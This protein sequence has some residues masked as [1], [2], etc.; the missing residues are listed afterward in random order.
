IISEIPYQV[1]KSSM[2]ER[3]AELVREKRVEGISGLRDESDR[4]GM[5]VVI[6]L[7]R[8]ASAE[9]VLNQLYRYSQLQTSFGVNMLALVG[10]RPIQLSMRGLIETFLTFREE[11]IARRTRHRLNKARERGHDLVGLA[12]AVANIDEVVRLIRESPD[13][14]SA[15]LA[16]T[17]RDWPA[18][19]LAPIIQL[20]AD[21]R[22]VL[23]EAGTIRM[24]EDQ[25]RAILDLRLQRLTGLGR[26]ELSNE[27]RSLAAKI[28]D[29]LDILRSRSRVIEIIRTE[30]THVR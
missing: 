8:D 30:L 24:S 16:L 14:A 18:H 3:I 1:N 27:V 22:S 12:I 26:D 7:K 15:R 25:A 20:I 11:V 19:D 5:R 17:T 13:P 29:L 6:E 2:I 28:A 4:R 9:V 21:P 10:G 23:T